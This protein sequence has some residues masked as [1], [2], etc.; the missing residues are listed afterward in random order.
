MKVISMDEL[1]NRFGF[2]PANDKTGPQH[3][4][5]RDHCLGLAGFIVANTPE[6][7]EQSLALTKLQEVMMWA[8]AAIACAK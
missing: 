8:N 6:G 2:H 7:R 4:L 1:M 3:Q 5:V